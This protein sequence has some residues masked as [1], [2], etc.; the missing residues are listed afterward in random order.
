MF[1]SQRKNDLSLSLSLSERRVKKKA[2]AGAVSDTVLRRKSYHSGIFPD[3]FIAPLSTD[4]LFTRGGRRGEARLLRLLSKI[5]RSSRGEL[6][7]RPRIK[8]RGRG[9][10]RGGGGDKYLFSRVV[11]DKSVER[12]ESLAR[13]MR[14]GSRNGRHREE[15][16]TTRARVCV[17]A[18]LLLVRDTTRVGSAKQIFFSLYYRRSRHFHTSYR[19]RIRSRK[20][21]QQY[22]GMCGFVRC[23][24]EGS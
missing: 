11:A 19:P 5:A 24:R 22:R 2:F 9:Q 15:L 18:C 12:Y 10:G 16:S 14:N 7:L 23:T 17:R 20:E 4:S 13:R 1:F 21:G 6:V 8:T 3:V